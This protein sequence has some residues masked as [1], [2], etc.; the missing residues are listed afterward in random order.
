VNVLRVLGGRRPL[1]VGALLCLATAV[2]PSVFGDGA[3][4]A[5][6]DLLDGVAWLANETVG[7]VVRVNGETGRV[8]AR[9]ELDGPAGAMDIEHLEDGVLVR[10][11][12]K[13]LRIDIA[14][15]DWG[16][17]ASVDGDV[18]VGGDLVYVVHADGVVQQ[19]DPTTL[20]A[21]GDLHLDAR[22][23]HGV[24]AGG[25]LVLPLDDGTVQLV[26]GT[27]VVES[28]DA[29]D[30]GDRLR[31]AAVG[32]DVAIVNLTQGTVQR[33]APGSGDS[34]DAVAVD[35]P[36]GDIVVPDH[37]PAGPLWLLSVRQG[38]LLSVD[39]ASGDVESQSVAP[40][41]SDLAGPVAVGGQV[42]LVDRTAGVVVEVDASTLE[43]VHREPLRITDASRVEVLVEGGKVF[44]NDKASAMAVVIDGDGYRRVDKYSDEGVAGPTPPTDDVTPPPP[45]PSPDPPA[46]SDDAPA[47]P[48]SSPPSPGTSTPTPPTPTPTPGAGNPG[49]TTPPPP[50]APTDPPAA[51]VD[52]QAVGGNGSGTVSWA[53]GAG[54]TP[55]SRYYVTYDGLD[56]PR[57][58]PGNATSAAFDDLTNGDTYV[59]EV[60]ASN[61]YGQSDHVASNEIEP[62]D[63]VPGVPGDVAAAPGDAAADLTWTAADG[64][65]N[66]I[67]TYV[68]TVAPGG[69]R[70]EV[71]GTATA[72]TVPGLANGTAHSF[73][74]AAVNDLG[75]QGDTSAP[76]NEVT[77][78]GPPGPINVTVAGGDSS[79]SLSWTAAASVTPVTY[80][81]TVTPASAGGAAFPTGGTTYNLT[82]LTNGVAYTVAVTPTN[83]R[84]DG[85]ASS[86]TVT[87]GRAPTVSNTAAT[88]SGD[89]QFQVT[90]NVDGGG[91]PVTACTVTTSPGGSTPCDAASGSVTLDAPTY[92]TGYTFTVSVSSDLGTATGSANG[93]SAGKPLEVDGGTRWDGACTWRS[94]I[95]GQPNSR[96]YYTHAAHACPNDPGRPIGYIGDGQVVRGLCWTTGGEI[97]DDDLNYSNRWIQVEGRGWMSN[98]YFVTWTTAFDGLPGC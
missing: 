75:N 2:V 32:D 28:I 21:V 20:E 38:E 69:A 50:E 48:P 62:N 6:V 22:P 57:T 95:G 4:P 42:Y 51:P 36:A 7:H 18:I 85:P 35:L 34:D 83:D 73:T 41:R 9:V 26:D 29:G 86:A 25:R 33:L 87:P 13:L 63:E 30:D 80:N 1:G 70:H 96:P 40:Q 53:P 46:P 8:D 5:K 43:I 93:T 39:L 56:A 76:S 72:F 37:L 91:W 65:G 49:P 24:I 60:W 98:L 23:G 61:Q 3:V 88:R 14:N 58:L 78:Y 17:S 55:P 15:L 47:N 52:V 59:F 90:F 27:E 11:D 31:V 82:G 67:A 94:D 79:A 64:R 16:S 68:V 74:V 10:I 12:G 66:D 81:I 89:R 92:N 44:V 19:L 97:R 54:T 71:P 77:P 45:T 84:G